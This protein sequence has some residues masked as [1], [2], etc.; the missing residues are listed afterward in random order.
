MRNSIFQ[1]PDGAG[2]LIFSGRGDFIRGGTESVDS[3]MLTQSAADGALV[4]IWA[5]SD[6]DTAESYLNYLTDLGARSG[7]PTDIISEDDDT[8]RNLLSDA[9]V[10]IIGDG[11]DT[12][13][14][15]N[16]LRG[17][18]GEAILR[19]YSHGAT[20]MGTGAGAE[21]M[22]Q[23]FAHIASGQARTGLGWLQN[24][25]VGATRAESRAAG[26]I[27]QETL[28]NHPLAYSIEIGPDSALALSPFGEVDLWGDKKVAISLGQSYTQQE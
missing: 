13:R 25:L 16:G 14:L 26:L 7:Y 8:I 4:Y 12:D 5:A 24:A 15:L 3:R 6:L 27:R 1:W 10:V 2:W 11:P 17:P 18:A 23:W 19:A 21:V 9:G 22:G 28:K 20:V